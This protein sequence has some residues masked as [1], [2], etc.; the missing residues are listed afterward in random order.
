MFVD[1]KTDEELVE[2]SLK[3]IDNF[4]YIVDR[5]ET[6]LKAYIIRISS[7]NTAEVEEILQEVFIKAWKNLKEFNYTLKFS[8]WIYRIARNHTIS[9]FRK[10]QSRGNDKSI[11]IDNNVFEIAS[12]DLDIRE[13][14]DKKERAELI[15]KILEELNQEYKA[16]LILK[17][18]EDKS[19]SE[20]SDILKKPEGTIATLVHRAKKQFKELI[21]NN[22]INN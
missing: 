13:E 4:A 2:L 9:S 21:L 17:Y 12:G 11:S 16:V 14:L 10:H 15:R 20:I 19:Y 7:F 5:Y 3:D 18:F 22:N 1:K 8:S 6:K